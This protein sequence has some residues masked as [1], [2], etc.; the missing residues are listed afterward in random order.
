[1]TILIIEDELLTA[2]Q[3]QQFIA[4]YG[5]SAEVHTVRSIARARAWLQQHPMPELVFSDVELLDGNVF[6]LYQQV[7]VTCPIIFI[8]AYDQF[9][10]QAFQVNGIGY[11]L[12]PFD[13]GQFRAALDKYHALR[14]AP[15]A[16][17][18]LT[19]E[20]VLELRQAL[21]HTAKSF[22][23][24][25]SVR[26]RNTLYV[27]PVEEVAYL[28]ADEGVVLAYDQQGARHALTGTLS[29][30]ADELDPR[31]FFRLNRSE[32]VNIRYVERAEPYFNHRLAVRIRNSS[33][34]LAASAAL[35]PALRKWLD[36]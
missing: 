17:P 34:V 36:R 27:L 20:L 11:L 24:R 31:L 22:R 28:Q 9:L 8:T 2:Q 19:H 1:M 18:V 23:Q 5:L 4:D 12:K 6:T 3:I 14:P 33:T 32:L 30:I 21:Q 13:F 26:L 16:P 7:A 10:L 25:F 35:T 15:A 29:E